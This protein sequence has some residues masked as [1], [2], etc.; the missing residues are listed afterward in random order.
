MCQVQELQHEDIVIRRK[1]VVAARELLCKPEK[2]IQCIAAGVTPALIALLKE[3]E[4]DFRQNVATTLGQLVCKEVGC[5]D[6]IQHGGLPHMVALLTD[7]S[8][9]VRD[10]MYKSLEA[11]CKVESCRAALIQLGT[12]LPLLVKLTQE[13][14]PQRVAQALA[15]LNGCVQARL[16][17][18]AMTQLIDKAAAI[19]AMCSLLDISYSQDICQGAA[20]LLSVMCSNRMDGKL[21]AVSCGCVPKLLVL[22]QSASTAVAIAAAAALMMITVAKQGKQ[23]VAEVGSVVIR[24]GQFERE[25]VRVLHAYMTAASSEVHTIQ[26]ALG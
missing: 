25:A 4:D 12:V 23:A 21:Q 20:T 5:R 26:Q 6:V 16:N 9:A 1:A 10:A 19:P 15:M 13:E 24:N 22:L 2:Y 17:D 8:L 7:P 14:Q 3:E 11:A 18:T